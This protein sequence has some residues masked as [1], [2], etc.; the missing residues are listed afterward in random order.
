KGALALQERR[1]NPRP[2]GDSGSALTSRLGANALGDV[3]AR[4]Q[5]LLATIGTH[6]E[7]HLHG[8]GNPGV[9]LDIGRVQAL[10][11]ARVG[12]QTVERTAVQEVPADDLRDPPADRAFTGTTRPVDRDDRRRLGHGISICSP[13]ERAMS[14][15]P[16]K[17]VATFAT[18]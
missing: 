18:S 15:K 1:T 9:A 7:G 8:G 6:A 16:G 4:Q 3:P 11:G 14:R 12:H 13:A 2:G 5:D 10:V 17:E